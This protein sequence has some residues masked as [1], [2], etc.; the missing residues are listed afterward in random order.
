MPQFELLNDKDLPVLADAALDVLEQV[1]I[2]CQNEEM[3]EALADWGAIVDRENEVAKFPKALTSEF[4]SALKAEMG[5]EED[6]SPRAFP[7]VG[8][9]GMGCQIAQFV[10]DHRKQEKRSGNREE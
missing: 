3:L 7:K 2:L 1:G 5:E 9:P 8:L 6:D 10:H 4:V